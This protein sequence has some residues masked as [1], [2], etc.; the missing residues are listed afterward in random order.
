MKILESKME[1]Q[2]EAGIT[3]LYFSASWCGPCKMLAPIMER[4]SE[5]TPGVEFYKVD[6][7]EHRELSAK[8]GV[9]GIPTVIFIKEGK[10]ADKFV[11][12]KSESDITSLIEKIVS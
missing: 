3:A 4:V 9:R 12:V 11:G 7:D 10:E 1:P 5:K 8:W 6:V 2:L